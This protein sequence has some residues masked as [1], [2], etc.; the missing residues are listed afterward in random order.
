MAATQQRVPEDGSLWL[1][2]DCDRCPHTFALRSDDAATFPTAEDIQEE[3]GWWV[4]QLPG[5]TVCPTHNGDRL[6]PR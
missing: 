1:I 5:Q 6:A 3:I 2:L 4:S